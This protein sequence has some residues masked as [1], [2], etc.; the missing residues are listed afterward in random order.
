MRVLIAASVFLA[1]ACGGA[2]ASRTAP[3]PVVPPPAEHAAPQAGSAVTSELFCA[4]LARKSRTCPPLANLRVAPATC[5]DELR[6]A[7]AAPIASEV[8][9][10]AECVIEN[11][12]CDE[13][14]TCLALTGTD[15]TAPEALRACDDRELNRSVHAAGLPRAAWDQ[16]TGARAT[17]F[18]MAA[19]STKAHPVEACGIT[20][21][22]RQL[23]S[24]RCDDGT[25]PVRSR[26]DAEDA[27]TGNVGTGGRCGSFIDH[28]E[29]ACPEQSYQIF[30]D[31]YVCPL[32]D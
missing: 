29:I 22:H 20:A 2:A 23:T 10:M 12:P 19:A 31:A 7:F 26:A 8:A 28:Y 1:P 11:E 6:P 9:G 3:G 21:A 4:H 27:R 32:G 16:R 25:Q 18:R 14:R 30:V 13:I 17:T 24:L 5:A 15:P